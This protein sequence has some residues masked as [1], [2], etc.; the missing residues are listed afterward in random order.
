M[1]GAGR[2]SPLYNNN[3]NS[4]VDPYIYKTLKE[5]L[6]KNLC[7]LGLSNEFLDTKTKNTIQLIS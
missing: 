6:E 4:N 2:V 7:D 5:T 1:N 3:N